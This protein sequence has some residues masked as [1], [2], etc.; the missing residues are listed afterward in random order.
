MQKISIFWFRRDLRLEDNKG[1]SEALKADEKVIPIF[2]FD[3][4]IL[5]LL[6]DQ[7]DRR[8]DYIHQALEKINQELKEFGSSLLTFHGK[9]LDV[10]KQLEKD[11]EIKSVFCNR[12]YEPA[13]I[14]R[15]DKVKDFL[16]SKKIDFF[17][18]KDQ[19][20]FEKHEVAKDNGEPYTV[21]TPFSKKWKKQ[22][23]ELDY[24]S[25]KIDKNQFQ[26]LPSKKTLRLK[27]IGFEKTDFDFEEPSLESKIID[28]YDEKRD[29]PALDATTHLGIALRFGTI[30][31]RKCVKFAMN[32]NET[33]LNEL[34]WREFFMQILFHFPKVVNYCF[35]EKYENI[36]WRNNEAEFERW[37]NGETGYAIVDAGMRQLNQ[38]G[39]MHNRIR[40]VVASFLTKHLLIDWRWGEAYFAKKLLDYD[41][42][43][44]NGNWQWAA[45]CGCD[46]AP[47]FRVFNPDEQTK[48]FDKGL[49]YIRK[50]NPDFEK[51]ILENRIVEHKFAR[52][53]ALET[54]K[55]GL[56]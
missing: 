47:Y 21:Y 43:A 6:E 33:W 3:K 45:G 30:S 19:V 49:K 1:L 55:K 40:M 24:A 38:T 8:V 7:Y 18:F 15:D 52:E 56:S 5:D 39:R 10:F 37:C 20:I 27:E 32:H 46:A 17:D 13:A 2:I 16:D 34:I 22:L 48:K 25:V 26:K 36:A 29:F 51:D 14:K 35:K 42:S 11:F 41:L 54:Y 44:N 50:W 28:V 4:D 53:R 23:T 31:I 12:D 9:P